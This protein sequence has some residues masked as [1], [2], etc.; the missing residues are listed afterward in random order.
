VTS[1]GAREVK[2]R[3]A[4]SEMNARAAVRRASMK[5]GACGVKAPPRGARA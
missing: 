2:Q 5:C 3:C 4:G 1:T